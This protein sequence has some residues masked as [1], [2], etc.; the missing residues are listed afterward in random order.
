M[1]YRRLRFVAVVLLAAEFVVGM[2]GW[3]TPRH[4]VFPFASWFLFT[5]VPNHTTEYDL[6]FR[7]ANDRPLDPPVRYSRAASLVAQPHGITAFN[8]IQALGASLEHHDPPET[9]ALRAQ[10][11]ALCGSSRLTYDVVRVTYDPV[12]RYDTGAALQRHVLGT[13]TTH[14]P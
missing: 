11:D 4:E 13:F 10:V 1:S 14:Q 7:A 8:V 12:A 2:G 6:E 3:L 5:L 9:R